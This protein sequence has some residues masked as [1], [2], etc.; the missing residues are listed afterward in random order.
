MFSARSRGHNT[1]LLLE[2]ALCEHATRGSGRRL[3]PPLAIASPPHV[4]PP[5]DDF[6]VIFNVR[7]GEN[8]LHYLSEHLSEAPETPKITT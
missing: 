5:L 3:R 7:L 4:H 6:M 8:G 2:T 1:G